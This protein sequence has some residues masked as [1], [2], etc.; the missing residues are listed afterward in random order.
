M[1]S[2]NMDAK[3]KLVDEAESKMQKLWGDFNLLNGQIEQSM[4]SINK[5]T[6]ELM[7]VFKLTS[8]EWVDEIIA[9]MKKMTLIMNHCEII[10]KE[11][12]QIEQIAKQT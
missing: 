5:K 9:A 12:K 11:F 10:T 4:C 6:N 7:D 8:E 3:L 1:A 2:T